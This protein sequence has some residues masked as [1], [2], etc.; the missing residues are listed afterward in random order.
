MKTRIVRDD[1]R[2]AEIRPSK[3]F[4]EYY[5]LIQED[6]SEIFHSEAGNYIEEC[7]ACKC[8]SAR[9]YFNKNNFTYLECSDCST[10]YMSPRPT[11]GMLHE[12][13][14]R[15]KAM[16]YWNSKTFQDTSGRKKHVF[17]PRIRWIGESI[18]FDEKSSKN[19]CDFYSKYNPII[20][21]ISEFNEFTNKD[22]YKPIPELIPTLS[23][24]GFRISDNLKASY[25]SVITAFEV[26]DR[27]YD[28]NSVTKLL[29]DS[30]EENGLLMIS[31]MSSSGLD[32]QFMKSKSSN[33]IPPLHMNIFSIEGIVK[34]FENVGFEILELSTPG[35]L[36]LKILENHINDIE[37]P[38][39]LRDIILNRDEQIKENFQEFLQRGRLSSH[40]RL[41]A[42]KK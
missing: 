40:L 25:Y 6:I 1:F 15:S 18:E 9:F 7:P 28:P 32:F 35:S 34:M 17:A 39:F 29:Y 33:I 41:L 38:R 37:L 10:V 11:I 36:D 24:S 8:K 19:Y 16:E 3:E 30:L 22:S 4:S 23:K 13:Y 2:E 12:F 14:S 31:S 20:E 5:R 26:Y 21:A 27:F 42:R